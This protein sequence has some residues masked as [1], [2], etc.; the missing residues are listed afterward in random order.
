[1]TLLTWQSAGYGNNIA[2]HNPQPHNRLQNSAPVYLLTYLL[3]YLL[4]VFNENGQHSRVIG[5]TVDVSAQ[6][7]FL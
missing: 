3:Q 6:E 2:H 7:T 4:T 1:M 5:S